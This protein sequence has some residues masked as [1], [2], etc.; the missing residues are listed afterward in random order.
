[1]GHWRENSRKNRSNETVQ[2]HGHAARQVVIPEYFQA[3]HPAQD[4]FIHLAEDGSQKGDSR[5]PRRETPDL[6]E[7]FLAKPG[8]VSPLGQI[9][10]KKKG[11]QP[12][13]GAADEY[14][15]FKKSLDRGGNERQ[16]QQSSRPSKS[17]HH[18]IKG[19]KEDL[20]LAPHQSPGI[21]TKRPL[22]REGQADQDQ[23]LLD[24]QGGKG[25]GIE[26]MVGEKRGKSDDHGPDQ[27]GG[28]PI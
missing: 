8:L 28:A 24:H 20:V 9:G 10:P 7:Q 19:S 14:L 13:M 17:R 18:R 22:K 2:D 15:P 6:Q 5:H 3:E 11:R 21:K 4:D 26:P 1:M 16:D 12:G 27:Q 23:R 25:F